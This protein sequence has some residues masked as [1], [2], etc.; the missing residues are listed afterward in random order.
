MASDIGTVLAEARRGFDTAGAGCGKTEAI[1]MAVNAGDHGR[2]LILTHTHAGVRALRQ[3]LEKYKT[4]KGRY[5]LDT[6]PRG[7]LTHAVHY[8]QLSGLQDKETSRA[9]WRQVYTG[10]ACAP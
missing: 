5:H 9:S 10:A 1:A 6:L 7:A 4:P 8:P 2:Q 3:R